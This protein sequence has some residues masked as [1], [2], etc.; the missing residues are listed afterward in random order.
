[1]SVPTKKAKTQYTAKEKVEHKKKK[2]AEW[3]VKKEGSVV[4]KKGEV[5]WTVWA[6]AHPGIEPSAIDQLKKDK[7]YTRRGMDNLTWKYC[8]NLVKVS[9]IQRRLQKPNDNLHL[10]RNDANHR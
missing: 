3:K 2:A 8:Q 4:S 7:E 5:K 6:D 1:M 10:F 9:A